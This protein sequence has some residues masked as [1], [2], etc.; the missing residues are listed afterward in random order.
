MWKMHLMK[1]QIKLQ[2]AEMS[3]K[4]DYIEE[5]DNGK[6]TLEYQMRL[7]ILMKKNKK[8]IKLKKIHPNMNLFLYIYHVYGI[9][10]FANYFWW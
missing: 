9:I 8:T 7:V 10:S 3:Y 4:D 2:F 5:I 6:V 1:L